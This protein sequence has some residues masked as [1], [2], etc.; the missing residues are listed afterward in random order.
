MAASLGIHQVTSV[1]VTTTNWG[2]RP[3]RSKY[4]TKTLK[5]FTEDNSC[6]EITLF[7]GKQETFTFDHE[8]EEI[9]A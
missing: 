5:V 4:Q 9:E 1:T 7:S 2:E 6:F 3:D 8:P